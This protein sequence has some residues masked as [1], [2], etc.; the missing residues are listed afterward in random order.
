MGVIYRSQNNGREILSSPVQEPAIEKV[1]KYGIGKWSVRLV[2]ANILKFVIDISLLGKIFSA[3]ISQNFECCLQVA[4]QCKG[5]FEPTCL[6]THKR[7]SRWNSFSLIYINICNRYPITWQ[8]I[9]CMF[10]DKLCRDSYYDSILE[11][12]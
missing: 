8:D 11:A 6:G 5:N 1:A 3:C 7:K 10:L 4:E 9:F 2:F 12:W